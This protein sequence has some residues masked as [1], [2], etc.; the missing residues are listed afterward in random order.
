MCV[1]E[2][3]CARGAL[4]V[5]FEWGKLPSPTSP[6][7]PRRRGVLLPSLGLLI[8][9]TESVRERKKIVGK[10]GKKVLNFNNAGTIL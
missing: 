2:C 8:R 6:R 5:V 9:G 4:V 7:T 3:I 10:K 1:Y